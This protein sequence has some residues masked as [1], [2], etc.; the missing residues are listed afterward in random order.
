MP[1]RVARNILSS[2]VAVYLSLMRDSAWTRPQVNGGRKRLHFSHLPWNTSSLSFHHV[3]AALTQMNNLMP[4]VFISVA[5]SSFIEKMVRTVKWVF[6]NLLKW[7]HQSLFPVHRLCWNNKITQ[8]FIFIDG[9]AQSWGK[10]KV[11]VFNKY[12][13][14]ISI[15]VGDKIFY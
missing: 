13:L 9:P 15:F 1:W 12:H 7:R 8:F 10:F 2:F 14:Q 3:H 4:L 11:V 6:I 5:A